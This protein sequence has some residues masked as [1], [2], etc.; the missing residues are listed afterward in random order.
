[1]AALKRRPRWTDASGAELIEFALVFP[2]L[3]FVVLGVIDFGFLFQR[4][5][6]VTNAAREGAR[7][8]VLP[9]YSDADVQT[10]VNQYLTAG[11]LTGPATTDVGAPQL[12]PVAGLCIT[13]RPVTVTYPHTF[14]AVGTI[15]GYFGGGFSRSTLQATVAMRNELPA[16]SCP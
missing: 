4:Y 13:V 1:M 16:G 9:G 8:A 15:A 3:L 5:E 12:L 6:V 11:G 10:R 2:L 14:S 7:V